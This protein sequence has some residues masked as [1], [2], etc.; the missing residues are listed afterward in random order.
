[1]GSYRVTVNLELTAKCNA[2]CVMCP[3][4]TIASPRPMQ[5]DVL[6]RVVE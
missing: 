1:M 4:E 3:R 5:L 6:Q 2:L